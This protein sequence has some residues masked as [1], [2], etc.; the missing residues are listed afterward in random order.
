MS[1]VP[2]GTLANVG[3]E[4]D[5]RKVPKMRAVWNGVTIAESDATLVVGGQHYFPGIGAKRVPALELA[6]VAL[7]VEG[8]P[9]LPR[10]RGGRHAQRECSM[11][12][13]LAVALDSQDPRPPRLLERR[14]GGRSVTGWQYV[15]QAHDLAR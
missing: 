6:R 9:P 13:S 1:S 5:E 14:R 10:A 4:T 15:L 2:V 7:L 11:E 8:A 12:L 3:S